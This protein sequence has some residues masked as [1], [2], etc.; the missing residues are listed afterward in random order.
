MFALHDSVLEAHGVDRA[1]L[2]VR[3]LTQEIDNRQ[4]RSATERAARKKEAEAEHA[5]LQEEARLEQANII[6]AVSCLHGL[7]SH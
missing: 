4:N 2:E 7:F 6:D 3:D 1:S 5:R